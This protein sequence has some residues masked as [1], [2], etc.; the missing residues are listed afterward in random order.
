MSLASVRHCGGT[1][2]VRQAPSRGV[3]ETKSEIDPRRRRAPA[4][5]SGLRTRRPGTTR[6][7]GDPGRG[8]GEGLPCRRHPGAGAPAAGRR[9]GR[10]RTHRAGPRPGHRHRGGL[11]HRPAGR[12]AGETGRRPHRALPF[13]PGRETRRGRRRR[14]LPPV[15]RQRRPPRGDPADRPAEPPPHQGR[16]H[17]QDGERPGHPRAQAHQEREG[18]Q[19]RLQALR[20]LHVQ[21]ARA[22]V[23]HP[24]DDPAADAPLP[25]QVRRGP[26]DQEAGR[27]H[28][29]V[30]P[31][32]GQPGRLRL[33]VREHRQPPVA[34][35]P[36]RQQRRRRPRRRRR[37]RPQPQL[38]LQVGLRR[39]GLVPQPHQPDLPGRRPELRARDQGPGPLPEA[40]R[41]HVRHQL[42]LRRRAAPLRR[43]LAGGHRH[44]GRRP[45]QGAGRNA[46][47][48]RDPRLPPAGLLGAVHHQ[49][50]GRRTRRQRQRHGDVH[51]GDVDLPDGL[52]AG[53]RRRVE[54]G[55]L[56]VGLQLPRRREADPAG[57][58]EEHPLRA[59]RRRER[60]PPGPALLL[61]RPGRR[62]L[63]PGRLH[64]VPRAR[65]RPGGLRRRPQG[66][67]R[68]GAEV[69]R[70]RRTHPRRAAEALAGRRDVRR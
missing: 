12:Q 32:V 43:R 8:R 69:P 63:H 9:T 21:P 19:G 6:E 23:D 47:E 58:R 55:R 59:L 62:R 18:V 26:A 16:L 44:P 24:G 51:P 3:H 10:P 40:D 67:A 13:R 2:P 45:L 15:Q 50:R 25:R 56:P 33:H 1:R 54:R 41:L 4:R 27:L 5:R 70:Q 64:H 53:P 48:L 7:P 60:R 61:G 65:R 57:V 11:P 28:R 22:R 34:Q 17:R 68:Q 35:E 20:P 46:R 66:R 36:A 29:A 42:P 14:R 52:R 38:R 37:R 39:R 30:V 49:R 31:A